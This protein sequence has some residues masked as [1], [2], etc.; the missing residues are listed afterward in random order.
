MSSLAFFKEAAERHLTLVE[1][2]DLQSRLCSSDVLIA[3][4][5]AVGDADDRS[6]VVFGQGLRGA[7][8]RCVGSPTVVSDVDRGV[9]LGPEVYCSTEDR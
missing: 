4:P 8:A 9:S 6:R 5:V 7:G 3:K 2:L 1:Q